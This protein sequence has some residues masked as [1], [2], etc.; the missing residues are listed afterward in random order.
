MKTAEEV[1]Q[2]ALNI[3]FPEE[4]DVVVDDDDFDGEETARSK[5]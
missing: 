1:L 2:L 5:L 3:R 4:N